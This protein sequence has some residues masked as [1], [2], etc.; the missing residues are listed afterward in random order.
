MIEPRDFGPINISNSVTV[1]FQD[2]WAHRGHLFN[3]G[4]ISP[5]HK[6]FYVNIPKNNSSFVKHKIEP[7]GWEFGSVEDYRDAIPI[8]VL[9]DPVSRWV[10][11]IAE[12][13][14]M[15][16]LPTLDKHGYYKSP[17]GYSGLHGQDLALHLIFEHIVFDDHTEQQVKFLQDIGSLDRC[18]FFKSDRSFTNSFNSFLTNN[19][20]DVTVTTDNRVNDD[21][22]VEFDRRKNLK[23][24]F[25]QYLEDFPELKEKIKE[26]FAADQYLLESVNYYE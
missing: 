21:S 18:I 11:G 9:R 22:S 14:F 20:Y 25:K 1:R 13:L 10:S 23:Q 3:S 16:C 15:Y 12:Y 8:V 24:F 17:I 2:Q 6:Y 5:D 19:G 7:L 26:Y 4:L